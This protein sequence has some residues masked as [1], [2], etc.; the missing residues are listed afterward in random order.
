MSEYE[1]DE[2]VPSTENLSRVAMMAFVCIAGGIFLIVLM[3]VSKIWLL[4]LIV[5]AVVC[6]LGISASVSRDRADRRPGIIITAAGVLVFLSRIPVFAPAAGT[7]LTIGAVGL[8]AAGIMNGIKFLIGF[9]S[10][11]R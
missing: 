7:L 6:G 11:S 5:G 3:A 4:G 8:L 2:G 1:G 9:S 10:R